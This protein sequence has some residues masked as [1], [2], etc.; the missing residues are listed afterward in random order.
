M[1]TR[2]VKKQLS[3]L[4]AETSQ[5]APVQNKPSK[6]ALKRKQ[7]AKVKAVKAAVAADPHQVYQKNLAYFKSTK[8]A[9]QETATLMSKVRLA[10]Q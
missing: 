2:F 6:K 9:Q 10:K 8:G 4:A 3:H 7:K 5:L 1:S